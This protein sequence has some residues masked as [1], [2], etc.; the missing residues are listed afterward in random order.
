MVRPR[1]RTLRIG[2]A[3]C[4]GAP[5]LS[6]APRRSVQ[7]GVRTGT[8]TE[9]PRCIRYT[10]SPASRASPAARVLRFAGGA[11]WRRPAA[12]GGRADDVNATQPSARNRRKS[13][14]A[15]MPAPDR[16]VAHSSRLCHG[17]GGPGLVR[18]SATVRASAAVPVGESPSRRQSEGT[19]VRVGGSPSRQHSE[20]TAGRVGGSPSQRQS[21]SAAVRL[22]SSP[23]QRQSE[24]AA[25]R[26]GGSPH[27]LQSE[28]AAV[29]DGGSPSRRQSN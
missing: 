29:R 25:V 23:S 20:S 4:A 10:I 8:A 26:V 18:A 14:S 12:R 28:S 15:Q 27:G 2:G 9:R 1:T 13:E 7:N 22:D 5:A 11:A 24:T 17:H 3:W 19:A 6:T 16:G 21:E